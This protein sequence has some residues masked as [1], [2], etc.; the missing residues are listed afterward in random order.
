MSSVIISMVMLLL[1]LHARKSQH[2]LLISLRGQQ[3][4]KQMS[5]PRRADRLTE[6]EA[7]KEIDIVIAVVVVLV[8]GIA[9]VVE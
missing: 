9:A 3:R 1:R 5:R 4:S 8:V 6:A 2:K 7:G